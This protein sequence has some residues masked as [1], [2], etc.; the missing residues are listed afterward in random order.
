MPLHYVD[1]NND[2]QTD[3]LSDTDTDNS[4]SNFFTNHMYVKQN[5]SKYRYLQYVVELIFNVEKEF[6]CESKDTKLCIIS[7]ELD[8]I[9]EFNDLREYNFSMVENI[10]RLSKTNNMKNLRKLAKKKKSCVIL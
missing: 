6:S 10:Y 4:I 7:N 8:R 2:S 3:Y 9:K 5:P 1:L